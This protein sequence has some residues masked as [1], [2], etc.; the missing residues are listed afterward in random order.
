MARPA[1]AK[2]TGKPSPADF[3]P[4]GIREEI[5]PP[6]DTRPPEPPEA[7]SVQA[8]V[9]AEARQRMIREAAYEKYVQRGYVEGF[10]LEDWLQAEAEVDRKFPQRS[11]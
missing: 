2:P 3:L 10:E 1:T 8:G 11:L 7:E 6:E 4:P 5:A 9:D